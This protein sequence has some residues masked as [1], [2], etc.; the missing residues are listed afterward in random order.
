MA[1]RKRARTDEGQFKA[2]NPDTPN[3]NE[4]FAPA[5][6][7]LPL[8]VD[9][10]AE[11]LGDQQPDRERLA[12]ALTLARAAAEASTGAAVADAAP[13]PIRHGVHMLAAHL[14]I[15]DQLQDQPTGE[16]I[17]LVVRALWR[18]ADAGHQSI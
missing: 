16:Q 18:Q 1:T 7:D 4:A 13:H 12:Q 17:P 2:D 8:S 11:F 9:S 15:T 6:A 10:L 5:T 14:L 3:T